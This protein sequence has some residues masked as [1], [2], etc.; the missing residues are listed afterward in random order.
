MKEQTK[1][2]HRLGS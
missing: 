1:A 2:C